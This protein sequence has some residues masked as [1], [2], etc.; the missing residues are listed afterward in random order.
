M[1]E[2]KYFDSNAPEEGWTDKLGLDTDLIGY[3]DI[4]SPA[5]F[6][7]E[8]EAI[9][10]PSWHYIGRADRLTQPGSYFTKEF[11][12]LNA[13]VLATRNDAGEVKVFHNVCPH[14]GNKL[15]WETDAREE[16]S[17]RCKTFYCKYHGIQF[18][19]DGRLAL[20]TEKDAWIGSQGSDLKLAEVPFEVW[21]GFIFVN[22]D[23]GGPKQTLKEFMGESYYHGFDGYPF[24]LCDQRYFVRLNARANWKTMI[25][26]FSET[27]HAPTTHATTFNT[28]PTEYLVYGAENFAVD[29]KHRHM[30]FAGVPEDFYNYDYERLTRAYGTGPRHEFPEAL[31]TLPEISNR[32]GLEGWGTSS[33]MIWPNLFIQHYHPGW[34]LTYKM[35]PLRCNQMRFEVE[36]FMP[37]PRNFT[38]QLSQKASVYMFL[39]AALQDFSLLEATQLGLEARVFDR[40]PLTDQEVM[41]RA[42]HREIYRTV[43]EYRQN[44]EPEIIANG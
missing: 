23:H 10:R 43:G 26:G 37:M 17:G 25:D 31:K 41:V 5:F 1:V 3:E 28:A 22:L 13:S 38:E 15:V 30:M 42:F 9:F 8:R 12:I 40:H 27:Y 33:H 11:E 19:S 39:D 36:M 7:A 35:C 34:F 44:H 4:I 20:L 14:R 2:E 6:D 29:G 24:E 32:T 18:D 21:N 16:V